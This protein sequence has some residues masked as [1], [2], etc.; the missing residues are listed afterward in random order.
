M[1]R[2]TGAAAALAAADGKDFKALTVQE[3]VGYL[4]R[5]DMWQC[6]TFMRDAW[7]DKK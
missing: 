7:S 1:L 2:P 4:I 6:M 3:A 5:A